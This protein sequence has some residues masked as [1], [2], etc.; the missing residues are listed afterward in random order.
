MVEWLTDGYDQSGLLHVIYAENMVRVLL[1][2]ILTTLSKYE[3][4]PA[5]HERT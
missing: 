3:V 2:E 5:L 1:Q 4:D